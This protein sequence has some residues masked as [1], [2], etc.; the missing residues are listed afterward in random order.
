MLA[1][2]EYDLQLRLGELEQLQEKTGYGPY[3]T[4][5]RLLSQTFIVAEITETIRL[6][7]VGSGEMS[8]REA[9]SYVINSLEKPV[10]LDNR[11]FLMDY[12]IPAIN[13]LHAALS[14]VTDEPLIDDEG[15]DAGELMPEEN[16]TPSAD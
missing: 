13:A 1:D 14:G 10:D 4:L 3:E 16:P 12:R 11:A 8:P 15:D 7:L 5:S 9:T 6:G 2:G